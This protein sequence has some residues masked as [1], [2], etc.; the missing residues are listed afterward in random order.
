MQ[1]FV[2]VGTQIY[3]GKLRITNFDRLFRT[4]RRFKQGDAN[5]SVG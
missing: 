1:K 2:Q 5:D 4:V 3:R